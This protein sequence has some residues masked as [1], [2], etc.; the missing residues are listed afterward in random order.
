MVYLRY[1]CL[2]LAISLLQGCSREGGPAP[3]T[4]AGVY[5]ADT[6]GVLN[7][8]QYKVKKGETLYSIAWRAG[9]DPKQLA[10]RNNIPAPYTIYV[11]QTINLKASSV[12]TSKAKTNKH[13]TV[14]PQVKDVKKSSKKLESTST[15][16]Y[17]KNSPKVVVSS[18]T[19]PVKGW[20]W[21]TKGRIIKGFSNKE[22][23]NKGL[24][25]RGSQGQKIVA[26]APGR[27]VYAGSALRGYGKLIIIKHNDDY[28]SAYA[29]NSRLRVKEKQQVVVGQHI[30]DMGDTGTTDTRL[31]FEIR[32][33][34]KSV[35]PKKYLPAL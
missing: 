11:G 27:V 29:H 8:S 6:R 9:L 16:A 28:L 34:G 20:V 21:P 26:S 24:D 14:K 23:G 22:N 18:Q 15:K 1:V 31:H 2:I 12:K 17:A 5:N 19:G 13:K 33:K 30:A 32:F 35:D 25:I 4:D 3:V 7:S 10:K